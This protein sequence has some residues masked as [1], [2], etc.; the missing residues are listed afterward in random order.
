MLDGLDQATIPSWPWTRTEAQSLARACPVASTVRH[1]RAHKT[2]VFWEFALTTLTRSVLRRKTAE[3]SFELAPASSQGRKQETGAIGSRR[4]RSS[5][6]A[7]P[8]TPLESSVFLLGGSFLKSIVNLFYQV[9]Q[10]H[11]PSS[12]LCSTGQSHHAQTLPRASSVPRESRM[13]LHK[14][15]VS[16]SALEALLLHLTVRRE[17]KV[18]E[19]PTLARAA[20][21][22]WAE[23]FENPVVEPVDCGQVRVG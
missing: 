7:R 8:S 10:H 22:G 23:G 16:L 17:A 4:P 12:P 18:A 6:L 9:F 19:I 20:F 3:T 11:S 13:W 5:H 21:G 14:D 2:V 15:A 1:L